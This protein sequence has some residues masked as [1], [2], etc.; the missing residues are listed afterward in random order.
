MFYCARA[1][2]ERSVELGKGCPMRGRSTWVVVVLVVALVGLSGCDW[3]M[4]GYDAGQTHSTPD[5]SISRNAAASGFNIAWSGAPGNDSSPAVV[6]GVAYVGWWAYDAGGKANCSG[7]P[8]TCAPLWTYA[9]AQQGSS[10]S[11]PAVA[12]GV[13]FLQLGYPTNTLFAFDA[14]GQTN[15]SGTP[16][17]CAP[18]WTAATGSETSAPVVSNGTVYV[19]SQHLFAFDAAGQQNCSGSPKTCQ[20]LWMTADASAI[21]SP[22]VA[23]GFVYVASNILSAYDDDGDNNCS[24]VPVTCAPLWTADLGP[25]NLGQPAVANDR[26]YIGSYDSQPC[27]HTSCVTPRALSVFDADG[28]ANCSGTPKHCTPLWTTSVGVDGPPAIAGGMIYA[29][30]SSNGRLYAFDAN[31]TRSCSGSPPVCA[32][33]WSATTITYPI[34]GAPSVANGVVYLGSLGCYTCGDG[35]LYA[36][37]AA[38]ATNCSGIPKQC[39]PLSSTAVPGSP[40][41]SSPAVANGVIYIGS[42]AGRIEA[43]TPKTP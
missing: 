33:L 32:P 2:A 13:L 14:T 4:W 23:N 5:V 19:A 43:Y 40:G 30:D 3:P 10:V 25:H 18:L 35:F 7:S 36:F 22:A 29:P 16:R 17:V 34:H 9:V 8:R 15:C 28:L 27:G 26:V 24:G 20:P 38:G 42:F 12:N 11:S 37:D 21:G 1:R 31:G 41:S 39:L 6:S